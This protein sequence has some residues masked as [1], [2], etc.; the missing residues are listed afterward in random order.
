MDTILDILKWPVLFLLLALIDVPFLRVGSHLLGLRRYS[1]GATY[2][3]ALIVSGSQ[4]V[5]DVIFSPLLSSLSGNL[6]LAASLALSLAVSSWVVG[7]FVTTEN[8]ESIGV[9]RGFQLML[10]ANLLLGVALLALAAILM[11]VLGSFGVQ[12]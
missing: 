4:I 3:L 12:F 7:Y 8:R 5:C 10:L 1:F 2:L 9:A 6:Q 11:R